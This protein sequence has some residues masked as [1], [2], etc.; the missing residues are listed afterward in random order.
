[1]ADTG[2]GISS[3]DLPKLFKEF[4]QLETT[5]AQAYEGTGLG[6]ALSKRLVELH[7][8]TIRA[9]SAGEG[10]GSVFTVCLPFG[11]PEPRG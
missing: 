4:T 2:I 8:G 1:M 5:A 9:E 10:Q 6:L 11:Q 3:E 7:G